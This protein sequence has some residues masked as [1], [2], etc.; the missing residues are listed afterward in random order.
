VALQCGEH[1]GVGAV[2]LRRE[3]SN[4]GLLHEGTRR[5]HEHDSVL[6]AA[7]VAGHL[8]AVVLACRADPP[9]GRWVKPFN[10]RA[11]ELGWDGVHS[12]Q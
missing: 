9:E 8:R 6:R 11:N 5:P 3:P 7:R 4:K 1:H 2:H 10:D 12:S